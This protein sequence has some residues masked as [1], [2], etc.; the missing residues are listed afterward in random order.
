MKKFEDSKSANNLKNS[1][2]DISLRLSHDTNQHLNPFHTRLLRRSAL[3]VIEI[4]SSAAGLIYMV[5]KL[6]IILLAK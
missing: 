4:I 3:R 6:D 1:Q 5:R 2:N